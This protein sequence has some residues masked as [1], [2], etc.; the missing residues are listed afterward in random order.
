MSSSTSATA[1]TTTTNTRPTTSNSIQQDNESSTVNNNPVVTITPSVDDDDDITKALEQAKLALEEAK[2]SAATSRLTSPSTSRPVSAKYT[3]Y[4]CSQP[5]TGQYICA[6]NEYYD[7]DCF[8]CYTCNTI[9]AGQAY[10]IGPDNQC[11]CETDYYKLYNPKCA[12]CN[13][14]II[15]NYLTAL[16]NKYHADCFV[17]IVCKQP[18][19]DNV[20]HTHN[21]SPYCTQHYNELFAPMCTKCNKPITDS[22]FTALNNNYHPSCFT[23]S[24]NDHVLEAGR[25]FHLKDNNIY[26][27]EHYNELICEKCSMCQKPMLDSYI[28]VGGQQMH[29]TCWK[30]KVCNIQLQSDNATTISKEFYCRD[31]ATKVAQSS[32]SSTAGA[33]NS[34]QNTTDSKTAIT[35]NKENTASTDNNNQNHSTTDDKTITDTTIDKKGKDKTA[36]NKTITTKTK[37]TINGKPTPIQ[38]EKPVV[39]NKVDNVKSPKSSKSSDVK[40]PTN[41]NA[42]IKMI[43]SNKD[44]NKTQLLKSK[45][46][47]PKTTKYTYQQLIDTN[48]KLNDVD[49]AKREQYLSDNEFEKIFKMTL[50]EW[51]A[52]Q[53]WKQRMAKKEFKLF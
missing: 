41:V 39:K 20:Y 10:L 29:N 33:N 2:K 37:P 3:C 53:P 34:Q 21:K 36:S 9:L 46:S 38:T 44:F 18:F 7:P 24:V 31:C 45:F 32:R 42:D 40:S 49:P 52:L 12:T 14:T 17:C 23:C 50:K 27:Q 28:K 30:C 15:G 19:N 11:Y 6:N 13:E 4:V 1:T 35:E 25:S 51:A 22:V 48:N 5:I 47:D 26:C 8:K 43:P 16:N